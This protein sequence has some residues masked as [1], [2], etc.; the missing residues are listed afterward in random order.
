M[1]R[2]FK[3]MINWIV[4][5]MTVKGNLRDFKPSRKIWGCF[6]FVL[7]IWSSGTVLSVISGGELLDHFIYTSN[8]G[9]KNYPTYL[10]RT[11]SCISR[12]YIILQ[13]ICFEL[14]ESNQID[15]GCFIFY[16]FIYLFV[17]FILQL[18]IAH[19]CKICLKL[20]L[21]KI[22]KIN[23]SWKG[24]ILWNPVSRPP[25]LVAVDH[26]KDNLGKTGFDYFKRWSCCS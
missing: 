22:R 17:F 1:P 3:S 12:S 15:L 11:C 21:N 24:Y 2:S 14:R 13:Y 10:A 25:N 8:E 23:L 18:K 9:R 6:Y 4:L 16:C 5:R 19:F 26:A 7:L 20:Y